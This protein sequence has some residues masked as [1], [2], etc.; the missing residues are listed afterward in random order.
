[1]D[2]K[3]IWTVIKVLAIV[4]VIIWIINSVTTIFGDVFPKPSS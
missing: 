4:L 3:K 2:K 1:M